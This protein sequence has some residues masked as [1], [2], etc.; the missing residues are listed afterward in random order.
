MIGARVAGLTCG[1]SQVT[2]RSSTVWTL[3][4]FC[5]PDRSDVR[6]S[7][8][9]VKEDGDDFGEE[10]QAHGTHEAQDPEDL[11]VFRPTDEWQTLKPGQAVPAGSHVR[12][13]LQTGQREAK[14]GEDKGLKYLRDGQ[15]QEMMKE[16]VDFF[17]TQKLKEALKKFKGDDNPSKK[18]GCGVCEIP[19][20]L[21]R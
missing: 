4:R 6:M 13:N 2:G 12:L 14:L 21:S 19:V 15:R 20:S 9:I 1:R 16:Q 8:V 5:G 10:E 11:D 3:R 7:A 17:S 18:A